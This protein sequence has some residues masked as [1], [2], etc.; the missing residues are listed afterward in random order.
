MGSLDRFA[1]PV[2]SLAI[3]RLG[4][5][6]GHQIAREAEGAAVTHDGLDSGIICRTL[7]V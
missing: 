1:E 6:H 7:I 3:A 5:A 2:M 4:E